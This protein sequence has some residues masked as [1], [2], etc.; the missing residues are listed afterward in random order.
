MVSSHNSGNQRGEGIVNRLIAATVSSAL[1]IWCGIAWAPP[2]SY[3]G[4]VELEGGPG[5]PFSPGALLLSSIVGVGLYVVVWYTSERF[6]IIWL[7]ILV[8]GAYVVIG[9]VG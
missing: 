5:G 4:N 1:F 7:P 8:I 6:G 2:G 3:S 9:L